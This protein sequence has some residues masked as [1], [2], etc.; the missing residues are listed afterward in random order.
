MASFLMED[1]V[2]NLS[3]ASTNESTNI[4][5]CVRSGVVHIYQHILNGFVLEILQ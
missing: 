5:V 4:A 1:V 2:H 3:V